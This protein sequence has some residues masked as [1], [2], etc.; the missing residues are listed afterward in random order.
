MIRGQEV[1][2]DLRDPAIS[3]IGDASFATEKRDA[4]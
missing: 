2:A 3:A 1:R 4:M